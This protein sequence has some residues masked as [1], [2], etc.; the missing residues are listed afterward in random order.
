VLKTKVINAYFAYFCIFS[1][2]GHIC[3]FGAYFAIFGAYF[4]IFRQNIQF[5]ANFST[6]LTKIGPNLGNL[7][8]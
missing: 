5:L 6:N 4:A 7:I 2:S 8:V 1:L 3:I